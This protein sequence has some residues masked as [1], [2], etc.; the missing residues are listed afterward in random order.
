MTNA[1][2]VKDRLKNRSRET[3]RTMQELLVAYGLE[4]TV[5]RLSVS[6]YRELFTLKGGI[7]L[8]ALFDGSY[9]RATTAIDLLAQ[10][11]DND[12]ESM[13]S[14]FTEVFGLETDDPLR[15][16]LDSLEVK[17]ITE[18]KKYHG[19]N[20]SI[21]GFLDRTKVPVS[22]DIG[23]GDVIYPDRV[24]INFPSILGDEPSHV[25]AYSLSS[26]VAEKFEAIVSLG[27]DNSRFKDFYDLYVLMGSFDFEADELAEG[28]KET[29]EHRHTPMTEIVAF[30][31]GFTD[32][33]LR[34]SRW[35]AFV[36]KKKALLPVTLG[37]VVEGIRHFLGPI[38]EGIHNDR[39]QL[40]HWDHELRVWEFEDA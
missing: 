4:R 16:D 7:F 32:D 10:R 12:V 22:I 36:R 28:V 18:F 30:E 20:V 9:S 8:Y 25:Y 3:G 15:F 40:G 29:F 5:Y 27:Y 23:F 1:A 38:V 17:P 13:Q 37:E 11:I 31:S 39:Q 26:T 33:T 19:V 2:S 21:V 35:N 14:V 6:K 34:L 24:E